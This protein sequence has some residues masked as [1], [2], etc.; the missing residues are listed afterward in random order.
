MS[1]LKQIMHWLN[2]S[3]T[4]VKTPGDLEAF[5]ASQQRIREAA[6]EL[7]NKTSHGPVSDML[8][9]MTGQQKRKRKAVK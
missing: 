2:D 4:A 1:V 5:H 9:Q 3:P 6:K 7:T 8:D